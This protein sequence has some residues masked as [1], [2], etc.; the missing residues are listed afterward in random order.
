MKKIYQQIGTM[1]LAMV[2]IMGLYACKKDAYLTDGGL[3]KAAT[4]FTTYDYL[5]NNQYHQFDT[6][7]A[8]ID[9]Y[10]LKDSINNSKTF[11]AFTDMALNSLMKSI[12]IKT[13]DQ[14]GNLILTRVTTISQLTDSISSKLFKQYMF[15]QTITLD[16]ATLA[17]VPYTNMAGTAAPCAIKKV[18][19][20]NAL[21]LAYTSLTLNYYILAY[22]KVNGV[23][24]GSAGAP[25]N[26]KPDAVYYCQTE[27]IQTS[28]GTTLHVLANNVLPYKL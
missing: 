23:V 10:K 3:N 4:P 1:M 19:A 18:A 6:V 20:T 21:S 25:A 15:N 26:D 8:L 13:T 9:H 11:F 27:G 22:V 24:D 17:T 14:N 28:S 2:L 7:I 12:I 5:K 16:K